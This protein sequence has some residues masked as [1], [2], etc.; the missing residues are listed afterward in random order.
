VNQFVSA[1]ATLRQLPGAVAVKQTAGFP[2]DPVGTSTL[3]VQVAIVD[4]GIIFLQPLQKQNSLKKKLN[5][6]RIRRGQ[7]G[8]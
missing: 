8:T 2:V 3:V 6:E 4:A 1:T 5:T 7:A